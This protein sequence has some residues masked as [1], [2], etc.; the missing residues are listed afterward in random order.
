MYPVGL[1]F[2]FGKRT[3]CICEWLA[4]L[5][6]AKGFD[7]ASSIALLAASAIAKKGADSKGIP[8]GDI[9]ILPVGSLWSHSLRGRDLPAR[10][11]AIHGWDD[12]A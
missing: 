10:S 6:C 3:M 1:L 11:D 2:G 8:P 5:S 12:V 7:T 4:Q 9:V